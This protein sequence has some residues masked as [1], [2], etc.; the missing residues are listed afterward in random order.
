MLQDEAKKT[1]S[2]AY[3]KGTRV[4]LQVQ[5]ALY[6]NFCEYFRFSVLPAPKKVL[7]SFI[8]FLTKKRTAL[9]SIK[10]Y[11]AGVKMLHELLDIDTS[12][13]ESISVKLMWMGLEK[14]WTV[15][16]KRATPITP[17]ILADI[18]DNL[19]LSIDSHLVFWSACL[20]GFFVLARKSNLV[21]ISKFDANKQLSSKH[22]HFEKDKVKIELHWSKTRRPGQEPI[23]Y[24]LHKI[25]GSQVCPFTALKTM[26]TRIK[27][28]PSDPCFMLKGGV[29]LT[30]RQFQKLLK[31]TLKAVG[32]EPST[33]GSHGLRS[34]GATWA[35]MSGVPPDMIKLLG[36]WK[37]DAYVKYV[38]NP[39]QSRKA[40]GLLM[41]QTILQLGL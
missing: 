21:P 10:N 18:R 20:V 34:G 36:D 24:P 11:V 33:F 41:R 32:Y 14:T 25:P 38:E 2:N 3:A 4:N 37:S 7:V 27:R 13:F 1:Q 17:E 8:Q 39:T 30:Y 40:A 6:F 16:V 26:F 31:D 23:R 15:K 29:P 12:A 35:S 28:K 19:D 22:V 5:W 9:S